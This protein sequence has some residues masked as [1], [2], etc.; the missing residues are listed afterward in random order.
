MTVCNKEEFLRFFVGKL[1]V[2]AVLQHGHGECL[3]G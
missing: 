3:G 2:T 1:S